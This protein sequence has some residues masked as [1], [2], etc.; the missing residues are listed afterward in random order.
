MLATSV[1]YYTFLHDI[2]VDKSVPQCIKQ[3]SNTTSIPPSLLH[4]NEKILLRTQKR[5][6]A[7]GQFNHT[8]SCTADVGFC[9]MVLRISLPFEH[10][11]LTVELSECLMEGRVSLICVL[12]QNSAVW[13]GTAVAVMNTEYFNTHT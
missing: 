1:L 2:V 9:G 4:F 11:G 3:L 7:C 13:C 8:K 12:V 6:L 5:G 10:S